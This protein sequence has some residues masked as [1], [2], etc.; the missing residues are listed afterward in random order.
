MKKLQIINAL[1]WAASILVT[2]YFFREGTGYEYV[3]GVQVI[4]ATLMLGLIQNQSRK[5]ARTR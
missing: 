3:L 1:L 5:R 2:S 4:A